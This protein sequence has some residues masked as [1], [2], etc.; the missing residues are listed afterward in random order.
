MEVEINNISG[1]AWD[2]F[3][4]SVA[5]G[6]FMQSYAWGE[7]QRDAGWHPDLIAIIDGDRICAGALLLSR[8]IPCTP[9]KIYWAP[10]GPVVLDSEPEATA[11]LAKALKDFVEQ[12]GGSFLRVDPYVVEGS[13]SED[14]LQANDFRKLDRKWSYWNAPKYVFW[15]SLEGDEESLLKG[16]QSNYR[17]Q[18]RSGYRKGVEFSRG[19]STAIAEF[20]RLM[21][22]TGQTK[23]IAVR[24]VKYYQNLYVTLNLSCPTELFIAKVDGVAVGAGMSVRFGQNAWLLYAASDPH[25]YK[26][27]INRTIQWEMIKWAQ[28]AGC[29]RYDF[30]GT[31]TGDPPEPSD[32][33]FGVYE[34]KKSFGPEFI[35]LAGYFDLV[36]RRPTYG[37]FR[38]VEEKILP[39]V[40]SLRVWWSERRQRSGPNLRPLQ[41]LHF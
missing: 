35:R 30:R 20:H 19:D 27:R 34:F 25:F 36:S 5:S 21:T 10:R 15:L 22:M 14:A 16:V 17:T 26:L 6:D 9:R 8:V 29:K 3:V 11:L 41:Q 24:D 28:T 38:F 33:G 37:A 31:A 1:S 13:A 18:I 40:Y 7:I 4:G 23:G 12:N 39:S 32:P 2:H